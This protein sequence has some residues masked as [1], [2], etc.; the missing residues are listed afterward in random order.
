M[1]LI[2]NADDFGISKAI[3]LGIIEGF[4]NGVVTSTSLM[5]NM[6]SAKHAV[7]LAKENPKLGVG[8]HL[9]LTAGRP[10][11]QDVKTLVDENGQFLKYDQ[12]IKN[13]NIDINDI[14]KEFRCQF[15]KF[16]SFGI[17]PTHIDTHHHIHS[18]DKVF[19]IV[20]KLAKEYALP[21]R[22]IETIGKEKYKDIKTT[23]IFIN[24]F[25]DYSMINSE[26]LKKLCED[27]LNIESLEVMCHPGYI[28]FDIINSSSYV[29][30]RAVELNTLIQKDVIEFINDRN[31][32][33]VTYRD[34]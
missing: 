24:N 16:F 4:K 10:I 14:E 11:S 28:D 8:I 29:N 32:N 5:C 33:L 18:T 31:I 27:N 23:S 20:Y 9:V 7:N 22:Y 34:I 26:T 15:N 3:N 19:N 25:Y 1:K 2:I 6:E 21:V 13:K 30:Q 17:M 12:L